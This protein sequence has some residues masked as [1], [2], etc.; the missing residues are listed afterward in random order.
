M[1]EA[2]AAA[3]LVGEFRTPRN[4][5][6][7][8]PGS[9][10]NDAIASKLGF[11]GGTV[12][13]SV[14][15]DQFVPQILATYGKGWFETGNISLY[16]TQATVDAEQVRAVLTPSAERA[17]LRMYNEGDDLICRGTAN[18]EAHDLKSE[19]EVR[20]AQQ[21]PAAGGALR[22]LADFAVGEEQT[23]I[24][25]R[26][27]IEALD[28]ALEKITE[29]NDLY[30]KDHVLPPSHAI[31]LSHQ[32]R[33]VVLKKV[34]SSVGLFGALEVRHVKGPLF[35]GRDYVGRTTILKLTESPKAEAA[36]YDV[37]ITDAK[38]GEEVA[39]VR[40]MLRFMKASSPLW[41]EAA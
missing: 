3:E 30:A 22:I 27:E 35:A 15:M 28:K 24:P 13:G 14:H 41:T 5:F 8:A 40:Y 26:V 19:L 7:E 31:K 37:F 33:P 2:A 29:P 20:M 10:H 12:P 9:I 21:R 23:D 38:T 4:A 36:W 32:V 11:K 1:T 25:L 6:Q 34:K 16:F 39:V 18:G 17:D